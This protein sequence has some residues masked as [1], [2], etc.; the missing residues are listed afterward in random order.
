MSFVTQV[1]A[2]EAEEL[3][4][5]RI[6]L[7]ELQQELAEKE[8]ELST[9]K[10]ELNQFERLYNQMVGSKYAELDDVK[11]Q[12]LELAAK[13]YPK[14]DGFRAEA[15]AA[16]EQARQS[17]EETFE[18]DAEPL[19]PEEKF[20]PTED[21]KKL[22]REVAKKIHPDL[23]SDEKERKQRHDLMSKL[24][25][26]YD[27]IDAAAIRAILIEW[28]AGDHSSKNLSVGAQLVRTVRQIA[29][30]RKRMRGISRDIEELENSNMFELRNN[31][32]SA[33]K[34]HGKDLLQ[35][36]SDDIEG[37]IRSI[38]D[39]VKNLIDELS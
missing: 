38:K 9:L 35:E 14:A 23:A 33:R 22:F 3:K 11:A 10:S 34:E 26:A 25:E 5:K 32:E 13:M 4:F 36:M 27:R 18:E 12:I 8:L 16:R 2:P 30:V 15:D 6:E 28:E 29:Q 7:N 37:Q 19:S 20:K 17:A 21:L 39:K 1:D 24:N 31:I